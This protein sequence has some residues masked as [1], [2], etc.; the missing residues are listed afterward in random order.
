MRQK[1]SSQLKFSLCTHRLL[2]G[3]YLGLPLPERYLG[4]SVQL[5]VQLELEVEAEAEAQYYLRL[6]LLRLAVAVAE[7]DQHPDHDQQHVDEVGRQLWRPI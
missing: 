3:R 5:P 6:Q 2:L 1:V 4:L 7:Q